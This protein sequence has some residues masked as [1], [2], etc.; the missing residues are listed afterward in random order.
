MGEGQGLWGKKIF[1]IFAGVAA[2]D[3]NILNSGDKLPPYCNE[4]NMQNKIEQKI[5]SRKQKKINK[6]KNM[7]NISI[8]HFFKKGS[9]V[10]MIRGH[11]GGKND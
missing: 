7:K 11:F 3:A 2:R 9:R 5:V 8:I 10:G 6:I 1:P 4:K